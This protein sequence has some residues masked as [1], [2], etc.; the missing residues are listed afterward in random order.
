MTGKE[1]LKGEMF[2]GWGYGDDL[3]RGKQGGKVQRGRGD[4]KC[5]VNFILLMMT[6]SNGPRHREHSSG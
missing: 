4:E 1:K 3:Q 2:K 6:V 5:S